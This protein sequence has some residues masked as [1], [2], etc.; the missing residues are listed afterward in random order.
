MAGYASKTTTE[1]ISDGSSTSA[2]SVNSAEQEL[3]LS[4]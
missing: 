4:F 1:L 3:L 2:F